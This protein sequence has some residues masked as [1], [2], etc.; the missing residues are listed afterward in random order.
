MATVGTLTIRDEQ[1][2]VIPQREYERLCRRVAPKSGLRKPG[3]ERPAKQAILSIMAR[4]LAARRI[5]AGLSE[6][7]L[8]RRAGVRPDAINRIESGRFRPNPETM[9]RLDK[10]LNV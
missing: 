7:Q 3:R 2:V 5:K 4:S 1:Y 8:A 9:A 6:E 10:A